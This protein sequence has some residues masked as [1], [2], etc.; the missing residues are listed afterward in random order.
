[1][2]REIREPIDIA[3]AGGR[4]VR[5]AVGWA[6]HPLH[7][8]HLAYGLRRAHRWNHWCLTTRGHAL[9]ITI[10][11]VG[12]LGLA[13]V[14]FL[15]FAAPSPVERVYLRPG[16]LPVPMPETPRGDLALSARRLSL[17]MRMRG[18]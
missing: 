10:A 1:M 9:T 6:R 12:F 16:G 14:S 3:D 8:C 18:E 15:D 7:R 11:D 4:L 2:E 17:S 5:E 13:I